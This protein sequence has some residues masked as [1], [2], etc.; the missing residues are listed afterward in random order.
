MKIDDMTPAQIR[1][2]ADEIRDYGKRKKR[3]TF[4]DGTNVK[5]AVCAMADFLD[6]E[7]ER[8]EGAT[9]A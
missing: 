6:T 7:A 8:R 4:E 5:D 3:W 2:A 1:R 9:E